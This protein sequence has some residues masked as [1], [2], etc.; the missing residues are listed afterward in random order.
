MFDAYHAQSRSARIAFR[1]KTAVL[2]LVLG[3]IALI[4]D[5]SLTSPRELLLEDA[6][7]V[8]AQVA[9]I[10]SRARPAANRV[11]PV[12]RPPTP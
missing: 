8:P 1:V 9:A 7:G 11:A 10:D 3:I 6:S 2:V 12:V 5:V 4:A